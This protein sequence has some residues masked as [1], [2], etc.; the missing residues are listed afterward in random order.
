MTRRQ[1]RKHILI[2]YGGDALAFFTGV[3]M[4]RNYLD[5]RLR[6]ALAALAAIDAGK[7]WAQVLREFEK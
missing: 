5:T 2:C 6:A 7:R 3:G 1:K 4:P